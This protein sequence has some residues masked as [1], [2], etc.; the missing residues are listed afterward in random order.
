[1]ANRIIRHYYEHHEPPEADKSKSIAQLNRKELG[2]M[3]ARLRNESEAQDLIRRLKR[4]SGEKE[5]F[6]KP[7]TVDTQTPIDQLYHHGILGQKWGV[8]RFQKTDGTRT[9][10]G[11]RRD[12][13][14]GK[15]EDHINSRKAKKQGP[16]G[17]ST[18]QLRKLNER[19]QLEETYKK[20]TAEQMKKSEN[21]VRNSLQTAGQQALTDFS[22]AVM[23]GSA[24]II[25]QK[26]S[27]E[28]A[29]VA[30][31]L[32]EKDKNN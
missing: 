31:K 9:A 1:M 14:H 13:R 16:E 21:W 25:V 29:N 4:S 7:F 32:K 19:L 11:K 3:I 18:D 23:L 8:R 17:L 10:E 27:P 26:I 24:K 6:E 30:F 28:F 20:L 5:T 12:R 22:K 2:E 15:S